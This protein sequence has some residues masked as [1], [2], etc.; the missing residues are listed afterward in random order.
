MNLENFFTLLRPLR[1]LLIA[2]LFTLFFRYALYPWALPFQLDALF[3]NAALALILGGFVAGPLQEPLHSPAALL[4]PGL[5]Q[6]VRRWHIASVV[7]IALFGLSVVHFT[8]R[9]VPLWGAFGVIA[10]GASLPALNRRRRHAWA[11]WLLGTP[12]GWWVVVIVAAA[13]ALPTV[14]L[15]LSPWVSQ[16]PGWFGAG[17]L[18]LAAGSFHFGYSRR[19]ARQRAGEAFLCLQTTM[20]S[21][22]ALIVPANQGPESPR[23]SE[24]P[25]NRSTPY[26]LIR[27][28]V[29]FFGVAL[30]ALLAL[31]LFECANPSGAQL[32]EIPSHLAELGRIRPLGASAGH[33]LPHLLIG[34]FA[35]YAVAAWQQRTND[36]LTQVVLPLSRRQLAREASVTSF[37]QTSL[38]L[39][40]PLFAALL[41]TVLAARGPIAAGDLA[42]Y[43]A[44]ALGAAIA[45]PALIVAAT[46]RHSFLRVI[47]A[48]GGGLPT[49]GAFGIALAWGDQ[50]LESPPVVGAF[51]VAAL[52]T[53]AIAW[54]RIQTLYR[55]AYLAPRPTVRGAIP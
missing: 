14:G 25:V 26:Q 10:A 12:R 13:V 53:T 9:G 3:V 52:S 5:R 32:R 37:A 54:F 1:T 28:T 19:A 17:G 45:L 40:V 15:N 48:V 23:A 8:C 44:T 43:L 34:F 47:A 30:T 20:E 38:L 6:Q 2:G 36:S 51:A 41:A 39:F 35:F 4:L 11:A 27:D 24:S 46:L 18:L 50:R 21:D 22:P 31:A 33:S 55:S 49:V 42:G 29:P 7:G 16:W